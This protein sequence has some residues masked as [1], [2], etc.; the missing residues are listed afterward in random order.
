[1]Y[2][3]VSATVVS[4]T[5]IQEEARIQCSVYYVSQAFQGV[6]VKY[7][8]IE[9][10]TFALIVASRKLCAYFQANQILVMMNQPIKKAMNKPEATG[11]MV[12]WAVELSQF[13][14]KYR[15]RTAIKAQVLQTSLLNSPCPKIAQQAQWSYGRYKLTDHWQK[16]GVGLELS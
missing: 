6:E 11:Q 1:M 3:F 12:Q 2:L 5:L 7:P 8:C 14:I 16:E 13:N 9:K 10:I 4:A 15:P